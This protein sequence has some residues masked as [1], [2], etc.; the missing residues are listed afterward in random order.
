[1]FGQAKK[2]GLGTPQR[3]TYLRQ[4]GNAIIGCTKHTEGIK[5]A[6]AGLVE[7]LQGAIEKL[8]EGQEALNSEP[9]N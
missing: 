7:A 4:F 9:L 5:Q 2:A 6:S 3:S 1:M 8:D